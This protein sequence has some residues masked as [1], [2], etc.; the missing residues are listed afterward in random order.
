MTNT[1]RTD[2]ASSRVDRPGAAYVVQSK[3]VAEVCGN[4]YGS[5]K[6]TSAE[7]K[8]RELRMEV[9]QSQKK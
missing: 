3:K 9:D 4:V 8:L 7:T 2:E 5:D 6:L 1:K